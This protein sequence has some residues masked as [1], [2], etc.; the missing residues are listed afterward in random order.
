MA[1]PTEDPATAELLTTFEWTVS[2]ERFDCKRLRKKLAQATFNACDLLVAQSGR[3]YA[4]ALVIAKD[5]AYIIL[6]DRELVRVAP[7]TDCWSSNAPS[8][9]AIA[10]YLYYLDIYSAGFSPLFHYSHVKGVGIRPSSFRYPEANAFL[11]PSVPIHHNL[12]ILHTPPPCHSPFSR[13][14][15]VVGIQPSAKQDLSFVVKLQMVADDRA[16]RE[17]RILTTL[18][19]GSLRDEARMRLSSLVRS[20]TCRALPFQSSSLPE[21]AVARHLEVLVLSNTGGIARRLDDYRS[22][23]AYKEVIAIISELLS[24]ITAIHADTAVLHRDL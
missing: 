12:I 20:T 8:L 11:H 14:T 16:R 17:T 3:L 23:P 4:L 22:P 9:A 15:T 1:W 5:T 18:A 24:V 21:S 7:L 19:E 10:N 13:G 6:L 2:Q